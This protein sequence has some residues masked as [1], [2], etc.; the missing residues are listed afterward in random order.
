MTYDVLK[1][2]EKSRSWHWNWGG[3]GR[4][5]INGQIYAIWWAIHIRFELLETVTEST[6]CDDMVTWPWP[7]CQ[8]QISIPKS[9]NLDFRIITLISVVS[10]PVCG[11]LIMF[12]GTG[13]YQIKTTKSSPKV[14]HIFIIL[15]PLASA[16]HCDSCASCFTYWPGT[17]ASACQWL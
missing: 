3:E 6:H 2:S 10:L 8:G 14:A 4:F 13:L 11:L 9:I 16:Y 1:K 7:L 15:T 12:E 5:N 17:P